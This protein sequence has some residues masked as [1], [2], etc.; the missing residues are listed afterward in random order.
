MQI[1]YGTEEINS[2]EIRDMLRGSKLQLSAT[3][4]DERVFREMTFPHF[5]RG[6]TALSQH[7]LQR[8]LAAIKSGNSSRAAR[9][10][11]SGNRQ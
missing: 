2:A 3:R 11:K 7:Q 10:S 1:E 8:L 9:P 5:V 4:G 6:K